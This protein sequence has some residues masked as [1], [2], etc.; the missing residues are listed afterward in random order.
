MAKIYLEM[1]LRLWKLTQRH[2][3]LY[4]FLTN[5]TGT[6]CGDEVGQIKLI[7]RFFSMNFLKAFYLDTERKYI[8][9]TRD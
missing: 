7:L 9:L 1:W 3:K 4:F 8:G 6:S 5:K 2:G